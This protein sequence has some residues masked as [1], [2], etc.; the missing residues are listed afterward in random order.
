[1]TV[2]GKHIIAE[3]YGVEK[4]LI[5]HEDSV[6]GIIERVVN[7]SGLTKV[8]SLYKQF[9]P[10]GVTGMVLITESHISVHTWPEYK[11]VNLDIF[12]CGSPEKAERAF[13][14]FLEY[15]RPESYKQRVITRG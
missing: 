14:L 5:S 1:M 15:F 13:N 11:T 12:T 2:I 4:E 3:L 9:N 10:H 8:G 6:R 7:E